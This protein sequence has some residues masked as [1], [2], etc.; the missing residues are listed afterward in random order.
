MTQYAL[1]RIL[2]VVP[3]VL[4]A[5]LLLFI[6]IRVLP[7]DL[8]VLIAGEGGTNTPE[9]VEKIREELGLNDS[10]PVQYVNWLGN[11]LTGDFGESAWTGQP[12]SQEIWQALPV[13]FEIAFGSVLVSGLIAVVLGTIA[14][15]RQD[16]IVDHSARF[17]AIL[18]LALPSFW[19]AILLLIGLGR[20]V[21]WIPPSGYTPIYED[22]FRNIQQFIFPVLIQGFVLAGLTTRM[23]RSSC[24]EVLRQ[25]YV[26]TAR[27]KGL[28]ERVVIYRHVLRN[29]FLPVLTLF[30]LQIVIIVSSQVVLERIFGLPGLSRLLLGSIEFRDYDMVQGVIVVIAIVV[31]VANLS[32]D[33]L[34]SRLDPR[35]TYK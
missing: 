16:T 14:A 23:V 25:D 2:L 34:Y 31:A 10:L 4:A 8:A 15:L 21:N 5:T 20:Y 29:A 9:L 32:V 6:L 11:F 7:G 33:L 1:R 19:L 18:G 3:T 26:R 30:G 28:T 12:I 24:L 35:I 27:A 13:S 22:P 17:V